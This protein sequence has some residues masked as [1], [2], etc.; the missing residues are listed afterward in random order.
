M[1][2]TSKIEAL[3]E[4]ALNLAETHLHLWKLKAVDKTATVAANG[5]WSFLFFILLLLFVLMVSIGTALWLGEK[6]GKPYYGFFIVSLFYV[7][8]ALILY[9]FKKP[10]VKTPIV[11]YIIKTFLH[12]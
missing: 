8:L 1:E 5:T 7:L 9:A 6:L 11:N 10:M 4:E 2:T 12:A 3:G